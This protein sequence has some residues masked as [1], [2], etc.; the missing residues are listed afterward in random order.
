MNMVGRGIV[1][2]T[3]VLS[4]ALRDVVALASMLTTSK[5]LERNPG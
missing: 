4:T 5:F 3:E 1:D 2:L